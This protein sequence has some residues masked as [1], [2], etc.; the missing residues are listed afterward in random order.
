VV[1]W[2]HLATIF[3]SMQVL[4]RG[5]SRGVE[6]KGVQGARSHGIGSHKRGTHLRFKFCWEPSST[7]SVDGADFWHVSLFGNTPQVGTGWSPCARISR[8]DVN[9]SLAS[10]KNKGRAYRKASRLFP[11]R[12]SA[13]NMRFNQ[14]WSD[15]GVRVLKQTKE[16]QEC[17]AANRKTMVHKNSIRTRI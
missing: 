11:R 16:Q 7:S 8:Q 1:E 3:F 2:C 9:C 13:G 14:S 10:G 12:D 6:T 15:R 5:R 17:A 4:R